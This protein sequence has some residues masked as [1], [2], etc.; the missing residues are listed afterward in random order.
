MTTILKVTRAYC[1]KN[2][3]IIILA[4]SFLLMLLPESIREL[5][6]LDISQ[7][8]K[9]HY[10]RLIS[11]HLIHY[12]WAHWAVNATGLIIY[13]LFFKRQNKH[14]LFF[15]LC[16]LIIF[17]S[18]GLI[19]YS[20]QLKWYLGL[21]GVLTGLF[22]YSAIIYFRQEKLLMSIIFILIVFYVGYQ[23]SQGELTASTLYAIN[24]A[25]YAHALGLL[26]GTLAAIVNLTTRRL[27]AKSN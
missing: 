26:G 25:S 3:L 5:F 17:I 13:L 8:K 24:S 12:S 19:I 22:A 6:Y 27:H 2:I 4:I 11:G 1:I 9:A 14:C 16:F 10:W 15:T 18:A 20:Q 23:L 21:S 7:I